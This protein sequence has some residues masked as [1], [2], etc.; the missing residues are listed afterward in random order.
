M[1]TRPSRSQPRP[2]LPQFAGSRPSQVPAPGT[3]LGGRR[4]APRRYRSGASTTRYRLAAI[5]RA[6][7][8]DNWKALPR[9]AAG[10]LHGEPSAKSTGHA[11]SAAAI[12][13]SRPQPAIRGAASPA[14]VPA[15]ARLAAPAQRRAHRLEPILPICRHRPN[16][17]P[18]SPKRVLQI[19][20][21][22][23]GATDDTFPT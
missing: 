18:A 19:R 16:N 12:R 14:R 10:S 9:P 6:P 20:I 22:S 15:N 7:L 23:R 13:R 21:A 1:P 4:P 3:R 17:V 11:A 2:L 5:D 8:D